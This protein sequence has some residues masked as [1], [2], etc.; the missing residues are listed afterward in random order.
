M[1][2]DVY[3]DSI[4]YLDRCLG[5]L[6]DELNARGVLDETVSSWFRPRRAFGEI[7][8][9]S[10]GGQPAVVGVLVISDPVRVP[11]A[12][13]CR[14]PGGAIPRPQSTFLVWST[15]RSRAVT[16]HSGWER[17]SASGREPLPMETGKRLAFNQ[18]REP[19]LKGSMKGLVA[20][21]M[22]YIRWRMKARSCTLQVRREERQT[23][24]I[25]RREPR[26]SE[27]SWR[28]R[29]QQ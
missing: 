1:A 9:F 24:G 7:I 23:R 11:L 27:R 14:S 4:L 17:A 15:R 8:F 25:V 12:G 10:H 28:G 29:Q 6:L 16:A 3:D 21:G 2:T 19:V 13:S 5:A 18:G 20:E 22:L 26:D